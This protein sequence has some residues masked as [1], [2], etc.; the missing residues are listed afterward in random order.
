MTRTHFRVFVP[1]QYRWNVICVSSE[2]NAKILNTEVYMS[3]IAGHY[4]I[5]SIKLNP[6]L[7][8]RD[9]FAILFD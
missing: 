2:K 3:E 8:L 5:I 6:F 7:F 9:N 1:G 4:N